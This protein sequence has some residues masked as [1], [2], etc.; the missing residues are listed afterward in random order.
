MENTEIRNSETEDSVMK[1]PR[2]TEVTETMADYSGMLDASFRTVEEGSILSG[3]I[4]SIS[5]TQAI[6][7][8]KYYAEGILRL[9]DMSN[10]PCFSI[11]TD[12]CV[13][14]EISAM[15][16][17]KD[18]GNGNIL[19][20][21]KNASDVLAW[22]KLKTLVETK[23]PVTV[24]ISEA[25]KGGVVAYL[26][27]IRA[28]IPA[29]KLSL[30]FVEN[31]EEWKNK[32]VIVQVITV[33]EESDKLILSA[34]ELLK[35]AQVRERSSK[36]SNLAPGLVTEGIVESLQPYGAFVRIGEGLTGLVH[37]SQICEKRI[38]H[39]GAVLKEGEGGSGKSKGNRSERRKNQSEYE[40]PARRNR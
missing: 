9:E 10:D 18:D 8:L 40:S 34:K 38:K 11:Q 20:S 32:E 16:L 14:D 33:E 35:E 24:K 17:R 22:D 29:S 26:H 7:D 6:V 36:V 31:L 39:P 28:F 5:E 13:G 19:L 30:N 3:T 37:I 21:L 15:V 27:G 1:D 4:I 25:V 2:I 23:E 12:L